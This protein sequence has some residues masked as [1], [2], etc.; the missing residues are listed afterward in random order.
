MK[1]LFFL[2]LSFVLLGFPISSFAQGTLVTQTLE[3]PNN[4]P[5]AVFPVP[6]ERQMDWQETEFYAFFHYGMNTFTDKEW[7]FGDEAR[8][9]YAPATIPNCLQWIQAVKAAGMKGGIAVVKHHDGFCLWPSKY[10]EHS[11]KNS[12][13]KDG[14]GDVV[15]EI[16]E[17]IPSGNGN[18]ATASQWLTR[19]MF[20]PLMQNQ[21]VYLLSGGEK[22]R[23][24]L[25]TVLIKNP[26]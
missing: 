19:F 21:P 8:S 6:S 26:N 2:V 1:K 14:K 25:L 12:L 20:P 7:G 4:E 15:K 17:I 23:L 9:I 11:V 18:T 22:K 16:A 13:W 10:T 3:N 5:R 24:Y